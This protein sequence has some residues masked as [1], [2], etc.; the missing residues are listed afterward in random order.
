[1][2]AIFLEIMVE[3]M[4]DTFL[5]MAVM[6]VIGRA[7]MAAISQVEMAGMEDIGLVI[8]GTFSQVPPHNSS[9]YSCFIEV[10]KCDNHLNTILYIKFVICSSKFL[11]HASI[12]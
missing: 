3:E 11:S 8:E 4:E 10:A 6:A 12:S 9:G 1:M 2:V 7:V 5:E